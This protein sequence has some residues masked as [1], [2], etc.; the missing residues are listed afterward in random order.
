MLDFGDFEV[1]TFDCY[2]TLIDWEFGIFTAL[3]P[4]L[5]ARGISVEHDDLLRL[6]AELE[7]AQTAGPYKSYREILRTVMQGL[8]ERLGF[9]PSA[10]DLGALERSLPSWEPFPD[11]VEALR[12]LKTRYKLAV[13]SNIDDDLFAETA[14]R[15]EVPFDEVITAQ[16]VGAYKPSPR[17]FEAAFVR[18]GQ[19]RN[20]I[21]HVAQSLYHDIRPAK[22]LG[23]S[24]VWVNRQGLRAPQPDDRRGDLEVPDLKSLV[25]AIGL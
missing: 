16:Q 9:A 8:G 6:Y 4:V 22:T 3:R 11:T 23:L 25:S 18:I 20:R 1:L 14:R 19:P 12:A 15:L 5:D 24:V 7:N 2:G 13:I 10:E 21:L 17:N